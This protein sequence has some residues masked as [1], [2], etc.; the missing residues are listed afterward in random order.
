MKELAYFQR[1]FTSKNMIERIKNI[2]RKITIQELKKVQVSDERDCANHFNA[3][4]V[5]GNSSKV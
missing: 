1:P 4:L 3:R 2:F 5:T